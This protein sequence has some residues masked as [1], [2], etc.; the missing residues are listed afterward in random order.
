MV[1]HGKHPGGAAPR[2]SARTTLREVRDLRAADLRPVHRSD[3]HD[4]PAVLRVNDQAEY[5]RLSALVELR[6]RELR[7]ALDRHEESGRWNDHGFLERVE[8]GLAE[9]VAEVPAR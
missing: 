1:V 8:A 2:D 5:A 3:G 9:L 4:V 6:L 7:A